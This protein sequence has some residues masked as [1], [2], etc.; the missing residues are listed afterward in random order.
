[1]KRLGGH[2]L[3]KPVEAEIQIG[4]RSRIGSESERFGI[5]TRIGRSPGRGNRIWSPGDRNRK[6][7]PSRVV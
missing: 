5:G 6:R 3:A 2:R 4:I 7:N 1:M